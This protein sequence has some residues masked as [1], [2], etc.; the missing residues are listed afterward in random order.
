MIGSIVSQRCENGPFDPARMTSFGCWMVSPSATVASIR[1]RSAPRVSGRSSSQVKADAVQDQGQGA[2][3]QDAA[4]RSRRH[5]NW[6]YRNGAICGAKNS[7]CT[8]SAKLPVSVQCRAR[9]VIRWT[10]GRVSTMSQPN[11]RQAESSGKLSVRASPREGM[12]VTGSA[13]GREA[14]QGGDDH[15]RQRDAIEAGHAAEHEGGG[16]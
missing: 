13:I 16:E 5:Q 10:F 1:A 4:H 3:D 11:R 7:A 14:W 12:T 8:D 15:L 9:A 6:K 2:G